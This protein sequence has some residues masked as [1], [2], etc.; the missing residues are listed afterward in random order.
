MDRAN[1]SLALHELPALKTG[2]GNLLTDI[3][4]KRTPIADSVGVSVRMG[5]LT[6]KINPSAS[7]ADL[8]LAPCFGANTDDLKL[9]VGATLKSERPDL[10]ELI[11]KAVAD[12]HRSGLTDCN[13]SGALQGLIAAHPAF[14]PKTMAM[15]GAKLPFSEQ[16]APRELCMQGS[17]AEAETLPEVMRLLSAYGFSDRLEQRGAGEAS[18]T[19]AGLGVAAAGP[20]LSPH[21]RSMVAFVKQKVPDAPESELARSYPLRLAE[22]VVV[23]LARGCMK[24]ME[25]L[26]EPNGS[27]EQ[28][29]R[30]K[31]G[32]NYSMSLFH[33]VLVNGMLPLHVPANWVELLALQEPVPLGSEPPPPK[34]VNTS[35]SGSSS[36]S[37]GGGSVPPRPGP[38]AGI[39]RQ[40]GGGGLRQDIRRRRHSVG[41]ENRRAA[42]GRALQEVHQGAE[43][44]AD[45]LHPLR[46]R[47]ARHELPDNGDRAGPARQRAEG[48]AGRRNRW[49][50]DPRAA[51]AALP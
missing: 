42:R 33:N 51:A 31:Q 19:Y 28:A 48:E 44:A 4:L 10:A 1:A 14:L 20:R 47:T 24:L 35:S 45:Y 18:C 41:T 36:S 27:S 30:W 5:S 49:G 3:A 50:P 15:Q 13:I 22:H 8:M 9:S 16:F 39:K 46:L 2:A 37:S 17:F 11:E 25:S 29:A 7:F 43:V 32:K 21:M 40:G 38:A 12:V 23:C 26:G 6:K 34:T